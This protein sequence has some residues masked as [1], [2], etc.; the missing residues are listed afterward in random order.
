MMELTSTN[1]RNVFADCL[2]PDAPLTEGILV[3]A[4]LNTSGH[5]QD[6]KDMLEQLPLGFRNSVGGGMSFLSACERSDGTLWGEH[7]QVEQLMLLGL[8]SGLV[9]YCAPREIWKIL[10]GGMPYFRIL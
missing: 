8:A 2:Q 9:E 6:I 10:P 4:P 5:T 1:V 7:L 3:E